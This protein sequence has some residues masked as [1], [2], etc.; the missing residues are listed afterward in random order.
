MSETQKA[1]KDYEDLI[2][3]DLWTQEIPGKLKEALDTYRKA[4]NGLMALQ[5][6]DRDARR[7]QQRV[8]AYCLMR[9]GNVLRHL[10]NK[11]EASMRSERSIAAARACG[12]DITLA[13]SLLSRGTD[14]ITLGEVQQ[15]LELLEE[16]H[17][18]F[19]SGHSHDH[20]QGLG[21][22][23]VLQADLAN[24]GVIEQEPAAIVEF[25]NHALEVLKPIENCPGIAR[26]YAARA[27]A[28]EKLGNTGAAAADRKEQKRYEVKVQSG[29]SDSG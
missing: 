9:Q 25:A 2:E 13:R 6:A 28:H 1:I 22:Y 7:S 18:L 14:K 10:G 17:V 8:L 24:A 3:E 4:E 23:W 11:E 20:Q 15:G 27:Q 5:V 16:A 12:D 21:W 26:A 19:Q 29:E